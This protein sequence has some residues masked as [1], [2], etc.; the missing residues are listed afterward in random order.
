M[1]GEETKE[2]FEDKCVGGID[3]IAGKLDNI[4]FHYY[5]TEEPDYV[6]M[7]MRT[8]GTLECQ[9]GIKTRV[10]DGNRV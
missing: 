9:G 1:N 8:Y 4:P 10:V 5:A 7:L 3:A 2:H 6:I